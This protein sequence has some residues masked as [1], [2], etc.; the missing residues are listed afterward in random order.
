MAARPPSNDLDD[1]PDTV[2]FGIVALEARVDNRGVTFP[3]SAAELQAAHGDLRL[4]VD[5][6]GSKIRLAEALDACD[7]DSFDSKQDLLNTMH[8][9]FEEK[10]NAT[11]ILG[12]LR[13]LVPF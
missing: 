5:P 7:Q 11:G 4:A 9:I 12:T 1:E 3:V 13:A 6:S 8:P 10:R 2:E